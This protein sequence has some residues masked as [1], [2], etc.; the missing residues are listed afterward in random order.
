MPMVL[1]R[2]VRRR[3]A[4]A[5]GGVIQESDGI[6]DKSACGWLDHCGVIDAVGYGLGRDAGSFGDVFDADHSA[7]L[8]VHVQLEQWCSDL[9][10]RSNNRT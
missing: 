10:V 7:S 3:R 1:L 5:L 8:Y 6:V 4:D 9:L 2:W